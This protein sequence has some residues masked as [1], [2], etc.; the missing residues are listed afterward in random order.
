[1]TGQPYPQHGCWNFLPRYIETATRPPIPPGTLR[2][3]KYAQPRPAAGAPRA[4]D[5]RR[6]PLLPLRSFPGI[7]APPHELSGKL[8]RCAAVSTSNDY[9]RDH[10]ATCIGNLATAPGRTLQLLTFLASEHC[11]L[12]DRARPPVPAGARDERRPI[13]RPRRG[14]RRRAARHVP[15]RRWRF[16][17]PR[18][19]LRRTTLASKAKS[20]AG[21]IIGARYV[22]VGLEP[23]RCSRFAGRGCNLRHNQTSCRG[24]QPRHT[25]RLPSTHQSGADASSVRP[26]ASMIGA[27]ARVQVCS[28]ACCICYFLWLR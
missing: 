22:R 11:P 23:Q 17:D 13:H 7:P 5:R 3:P 27:G 24:W 28:L 14:P 2:E 8:A 15:A 9:P 12:A 20:W 18:Y 26:A 25:F 10:K 21:G 16:K 6:S 4:R 1:M 19:L